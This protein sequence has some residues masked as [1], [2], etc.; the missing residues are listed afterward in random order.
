MHHKGDFEAF[1]QIGGEFRTI[2]SPRKTT[3]CRNAH[4]GS[5]IAILIIQ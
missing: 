5:P 2:E 4:S 1:F 3:Q